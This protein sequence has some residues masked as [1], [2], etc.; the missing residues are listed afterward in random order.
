M[1]LAHSVERAGGTRRRWLG[2]GVPGG[3]VER[4]LHDLVRPLPAVPNFSFGSIA[5]SSGRFT[6][7]AVKSLFGQELSVSV[8]TEFSG[9][10]PLTR[11]PAPGRSH[12]AAG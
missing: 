4:P 1:P 9:K 12:A 3:G 8:A 2:V 7:G 5:P 6:E 10:R 11:R